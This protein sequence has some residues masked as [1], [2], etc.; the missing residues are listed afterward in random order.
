MGLCTGYTA[1]RLVVATLS[2]LFLLRYSPSKP[3]SVLDHDKAY[4]L[5]DACTVYR[6]PLNDFRWNS[7]TK[8]ARSPVELAVAPGSTR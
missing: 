5:F 7:A 2:R 6:V 3:L 1:V 4:G 8:T